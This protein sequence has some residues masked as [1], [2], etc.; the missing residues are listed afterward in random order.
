MIL[1]EMLTGRVPFD[2]DTPLA[3]AMQH[4]LEAPRIRAS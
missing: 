1:Y 2:A 3:V 4:K